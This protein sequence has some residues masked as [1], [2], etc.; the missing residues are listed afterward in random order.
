[1]DPSCPEPTQTRVRLFA[2]FL[3][4]GFNRQEFLLDFAQVH[5]GQPEHI[6]AALVAAPAHVKQFA[7]LMQGCVSDY[8]QRYGVITLD[9]GD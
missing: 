2:N 6:S 8:E 1:M 4:V 7:A 3:R 9:R 5:D